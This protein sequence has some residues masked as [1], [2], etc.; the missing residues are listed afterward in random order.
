MRIRTAVVAAVICWAFITMPMAHALSACDGYPIR[1]QLGQD[2]DKATPDVVAVRCPTP[3]LPAAG[4]IVLQP[5][6]AL[7][8]WTTSNDTRHRRPT[9][10]EPPPPRP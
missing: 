1:A 7:I 5:A 2:P 6:I 4:T 3:Y 9:G 8:S 10:S